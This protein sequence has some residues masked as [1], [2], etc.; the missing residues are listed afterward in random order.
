MAANM[1]IIA[2]RRIKRR[3]AELFT[4]IGRF[5]HQILTTTT[6]TQKGRTM[7]TQRR[8][9]TLI[10]LLV[11][12]AIIAILAAILFPVFAKAREKARQASCASN[13]RQIGLGVMQY[14]Q[15]NDE[16][17]P[18]QNPLYAGGPGPADWNSPIT[19][20]TPG[21]AS[22]IYPYVKSTGVYICPDDSNWKMNKYSN[23]QPC[24]VSYGTMMSHWYDTH[25]W[26]QQAND[27][28]TDGSINRSLGGHSLAGVNSPSAKGLF[29]EQNDWHDPDNSGGYRKMICFVDGHVKLSRAADYAPSQTTGINEVVQ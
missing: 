17:F 29:H 21:W 4:D 28:S 15:D 7:N 5:H 22:Q 9:F 25:Y 12:I 16:K 14:T 10:E 3:Q 19:T 2:L 24:N 11:V 8:A 27:G 23:D 1:G 13:M 18:H 6:S 20:N 26:N